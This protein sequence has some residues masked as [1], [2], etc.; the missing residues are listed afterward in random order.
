M[1]PGASGPNG[2]RARTRDD[3]SRLRRRAPAIQGSADRRPRERTIA[4]RSRSAAQPNEGG[5]AEGTTFRPGTNRSFLILG[6]GPA[7]AP[8]MA[9]TDPLSLGEAKRLSGNAD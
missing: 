6:R 2:R 5:T 8:I 4:R 3:P 7:E 9:T 1:D